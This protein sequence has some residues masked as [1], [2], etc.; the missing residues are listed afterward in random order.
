MTSLKVFH[1]NFWSKPFLSNSLFKVSTKTLHGSAQ[2]KSLT[3]KTLP[4]S[5]VTPNFCLNFLRFKTEKIKTNVCWKCGIDVSSV[6]FCDKCH[7]LQKPNLKQNYFELF[8]VPLSFDIATKDLTQRYRKILNE[9][10]PDRFSSKEEDEQVLSEEYSSLV[11]KAYATLLNPLDRGLYLL[12]LEGISIEEEAV[13]MDAEMLMY[14]MEKNEEVEEADSEQAFSELRDG[15]QKDMDR[16]IKQ[17][18]EAYMAKDFHKM[19]LVLSKMKYYES[20][21]MKIK[22]RK[23]QLN[24]PN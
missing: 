6:F 18:N 11:N 14:I 1:K 12:N 8:G 20:L 15:I 19:K 3:F 22:E 13:T 2:L 4:G 21:L 24:I 23:Q 10:H 17:T 9:L 7:H 5:S 16:L